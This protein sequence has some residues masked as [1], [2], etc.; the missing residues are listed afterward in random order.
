MKIMEGEIDTFR[1]RLRAADPQTY[2]DIFV[3]IL[4][5]VLPKMGEESPEDP[6]QDARNFFDQF[7]VNLKRGNRK[8]QR[9]NYVMRAS[10]INRCT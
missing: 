8:Q 7:E 6:K 9:S 4:P 2:L 1:E 10:I 5:Y 3:K